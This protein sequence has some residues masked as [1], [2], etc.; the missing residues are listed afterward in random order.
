MKT[1]H[2]LSRQD[3]LDWLRLWRSENVGPVAFRHLLASH[4]SAAAA[5][6]AL[7]ELAARGG[8]KRP[9]RVASQRR[10]AQELAAIE[11]LGG[12][13]L[14]QGEA[15]FPPLLATLPD[16][17]PMLCV[18]GNPH[19]LKTPTLAV[20][21][22]RNASINGRKLAHRIAHDL[23]EAGFLVI[24]GLARGIDTAA[25]AGALA[26][27]RS[28]GTVAV[29]AGGADVIYPPE[30]ASLYDH[31][32][33]LGAVVSEMPP[34]T[35]P[36]AKLFPRR[37][38]IISGA[39]LGVVVVEASARSGSLIT[40]RLAGEQ[41]REVMAVPG[42]P[43]DPRA[44]GPNHLIRQGA[45]LVGSAA[46]VIEALGPP[47]RRALA[48]PDEPAFSPPPVAIA[49]QAELDMARHRLGRE[50]GPGAVT[51][52]ELIRRCQLSPSAVAVALVELELAGRLERQPGNR[53]ALVADL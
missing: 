10:A 8:R 50:L 14:A 48:A 5:L 23:A 17:P 28:P 27:G 30:N 32:L 38:R 51:V 52:D 44:E 53:V 45:T 36:Q 29:L 18:L 7:P 31:I 33:G 15:G 9:I 40:A 42:S 3:R 1:C 46:E 21:G 13:L 49:P 4:G 16:A 24:S 39:A 20:V 47:E 6:E 34:G 35:E 11:Q 41:G 22:A 19:I 37:N 25:H 26:A 43:L 12:H 2:T